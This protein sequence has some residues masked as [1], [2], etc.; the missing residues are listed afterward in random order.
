V[1]IIVVGGGVV[2]A[3]VAYELACRGAAVRIIDTRGIG[4]GAT[5][6]SAGMLAPHIEAH[7][8]PL[9]T[10][11]IR[12]LALYDRF[13]ARLVD[14][15][16][17]TVE[18]ERGGTLQVA[19]DA[20]E[21]EELCSLAR[22][23]KS[24]GVTHTLVGA[25]DARRFE[26]QI[27]GVAIAAL[28]VAEHG[29]VAAEAMT[30]ALVSAAVRRGATM[31]AAHVLAVHGGATPRV[32]TANGPLECDA[33]VVAAGSWAGALENPPATPGHVKPV[34]GQL[35]ELRLP[36]RAASRIVWGGRCYV[37]P[38]RDGTAL[39]GATVEDAGFNE[40]ATVAGVGQLLESAVD[41]L[42]ALASASF[43]G[44]KVGLRPLT[45]DGLPVIGAS[46]TMRQVF[47]ATGHYRNGVLL[48]P[49]TA[50]LLADLVTEGRPDPDL[51]AVSPERLGL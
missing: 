48:A 7:V 20:R 15:S 27:A 24:S 42:P 39:V 3:A 6:A 50:E 43:L 37:V 18:Y 32:I 12:S 11:G 49:V 19:V 23:L 41:L 31:T 47:Y 30:R 40:S 26:P 45:A 28:H 1:T 9:R 22:A 25:E 13:V 4:Q 38:W 2:G 34:R 29:Y 5:R 14:D 36:A 46:S 33:V 10:L 17:E 44:V 16:G 35:L 21:E 51:A 8:E